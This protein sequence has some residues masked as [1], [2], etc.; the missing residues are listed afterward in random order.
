LAFVLTFAAGSVS[1]QTGSYSVAGVDLDGTTEYGG[2]MTVEAQG[3]AYRV[4]WETGGEPIEGIGVL[5]GSVLSV[6]Y[7]GAC[8]VVAYT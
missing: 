3:D 1:A 7:G 2:R 5:V 4:V 6:A 8:G